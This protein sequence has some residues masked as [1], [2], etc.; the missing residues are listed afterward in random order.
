MEISVGFADNKI[1]LAGYV[2][3]QTVL[4]DIFIPRDGVEISGPISVRYEKHPWVEQFEIDGIRPIVQKRAGFGIKT[5]ERFV[6]S[7]NTIYASAFE[8]FNRYSEPRSYFEYVT[9]RWIDEYSDQEHLKLFKK[10]CGYV[11]NMWREGNEEMYDV[12][13]NTVLPIMKQ[14]SRIWE[15]FLSVITEEFK[16][17]L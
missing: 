2:K 8:D 12:A 10:F 4:G 15:I 16:G 5:F 3:D 1:D 13:M 9:K 11:E 14:D 7:L 17:E 6:Q